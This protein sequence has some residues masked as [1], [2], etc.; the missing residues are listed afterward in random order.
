MHNFCMRL[1]PFTFV[2]L[3]ILDAIACNG[4]DE[5]AGQPDAYTTATLWI[6]IAIVLV[7]SRVEF[8]AFL[9]VT[10]RCISNSS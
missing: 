5:E 4:V 8:L 6:D 2:A 9:S 7:L 10:F 3:P 1:W